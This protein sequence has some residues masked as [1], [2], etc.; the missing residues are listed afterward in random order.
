MALKSQQTHQAGLN[1]VPKGWM[2][3]PLFPFP[4]F[5]LMLTAPCRLLLLDTIDLDV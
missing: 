2:C 4:L 3:K 5:F 1:I